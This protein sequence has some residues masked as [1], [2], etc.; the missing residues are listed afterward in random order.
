MSMGL[1]VSEPSLE[2]GPLGYEWL[3]RRHRC[4]YFARGC[5]SDDPVRRAFEKNIVCQNNSS[6]QQGHLPSNLDPFTSPGSLSE[7]RKMHD[8]C[9]NQLQ[10]RSRQGIDIA[11]VLAKYRRRCI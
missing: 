1:F 2:L 6:F 8:L 3:T 10:L 9:G 7:L 4:R 11:A 5:Q